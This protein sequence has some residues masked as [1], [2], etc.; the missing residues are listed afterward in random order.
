M[1]AIT[2]GDGRNSYGVDSRDVDLGGLKYAARLDLFPLGHFALGNDLY[3]SDLL[4][5]K[6][7][8]FM[9]GGAWSYNV[10]ASNTTGEGH[11]DF[12]LYNSNGDIALPDY[13]QIYLDFLAKY[14]GFSLLVEC[15]NASATSLEDRFTGTAA[16]TALAPGQISTFLALGNSYNTQLGYVTKSG[17]SLD[18]RYGKANPEFALI[19]TSQ[20]ADLENYTI[21]FS[22]YFKGH[23]LKLQTAYSLVQGPESPTNQVF[24]L[25]MQLAF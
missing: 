15:A 13:R 25:M 7:P 3:S 5:E 10:G 8:K 22:K 23:H 4:H 2:S 19:A 1:I 24:E 21:G 6:K 17:Y 14:R 12:L 11:G 9:I 20:L 18:F 16:G